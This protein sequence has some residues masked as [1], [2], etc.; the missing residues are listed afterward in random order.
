M[1]NKI[2]IVCPDDDSPYLYLVDEQEN[3]L[4]RVDYDHHP[5]MVMHNVAQAICESAGI[6][7]EGLEGY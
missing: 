3:E 6:E 4:C 1:T 7:F 5:D 2:K